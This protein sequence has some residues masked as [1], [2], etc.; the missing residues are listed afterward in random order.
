VTRKR[1]LRAGSGATPAFAR[2]VAMTPRR[3]R[4]LGGAA[5]LVAAM[6]RPPGPAM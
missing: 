5:G 1:R 6:L 4:A 2:S 3:A